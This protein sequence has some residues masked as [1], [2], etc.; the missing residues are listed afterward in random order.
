MYAD[1]IGDVPKDQGSQRLGA[2][3][4]EVD[5]SAQDGLHD[6]IDG[7]LPLVDALDE[8]L[9]GLE[10]FFDVWG[11]HMDATGFDDHRVNETTEFLMFLNTYS[12]ND[13]GQL[14]VD[15][16]T[17]EQVETFNEHILAN[18]QYIELVFRDKA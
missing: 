4:K 11:K 8:E 18:N 16:S 10:A 15:P 1:L 2:M 9:C 6:P 14:V 13:Q 3:L 17:R 12:Y 7:P 5:L